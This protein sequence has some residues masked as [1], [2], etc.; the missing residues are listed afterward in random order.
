[1]TLALGVIAL[2]ACG[3]DQPLLV[4]QV[5]SDARAGDEV[6]RVEVA[7]LRADDLGQ[8]VAS[9]VALRETTL[10]AG[11]D[12]LGGLR[13]LQEELE[14][15]GDYLARA[16]LLS[17]STIVGERRALVQVRESIVVTLVITSACTGVMCDVDVEGRP[18]TCRGG[19]C[20]DARC[21]PESPQ[22]CPPDA[23]DV[24]TDCA[25]GPAC[26]R[27]RCI[28]GE[29]GSVADDSACPGGRCDRALGC[30]GASDAGPLD[31]GMSDAGMADA[32]MPD[33]GF[34]HDPGDGCTNPFVLDAPMM[35]VG[36]TCEATD[37]EPVCFSSGR[38]D[39]WFALPGR[40]DLRLDTNNQLHLGTGALCG[41]LAGGRC[42]SVGGMITGTFG[43][44]NED[45]II[46]EKRS[47]CGP[48]IVEVMSC[49]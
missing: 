16:R 27:G 8:P 3:P 13:V 17:G 38:E 28:A 4:V 21:A 22:F 18:L 6:D 46:L 44:P 20:V 15:P 31:A 25:D 12:L 48:Y 7:V 2:T 10:A 42:Q 5:R 33:A 24:D 37:T 29:C 45:F 43:P 23:C 35:I 47:G 40:C 19:A 9:P 1:M 11:D 30:V 26:L 41:S 39:V 49:E 32:G 36:N 14:Q 34:V